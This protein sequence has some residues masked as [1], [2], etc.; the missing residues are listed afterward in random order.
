MPESGM[1][2]I[3][4]IGCSGENIF[5]QQLIINLKAQNAGRK[6]FNNELFKTHRDFVVS[7]RDAVDMSNYLNRLDS[8]NVSIKIFADLLQKNEEILTKL[9][10]INKCNKI[11]IHMLECRIIHKSNKFPS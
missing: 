5:Y 6:L 8:N 4:F 1:G 9:M 2:L 3:K 11:K 10:N 7:A